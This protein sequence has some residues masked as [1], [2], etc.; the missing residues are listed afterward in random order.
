VDSNYRSK[1]IGRLLLTE[2]ERFA[3]N[4]GADGIGLDSGNRT[5]HKNAPQFYEKMG[6]AAKSTG[7]AKPLI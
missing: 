1:G 3:E 6:Y 7:Y 5:E 4:L 2:A